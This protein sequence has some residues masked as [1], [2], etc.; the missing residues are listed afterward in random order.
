MIAIL[1]VAV[2]V[3]AACGLVRL[4]CW[5]L[6]PATAIYWG[7]SVIEGIVTGVGVRTITLMLFAGATFLQLFYFIG[8]L[9]FDEQK[10]AAPAP[11]PLRP[12]LARAMQSAIG[13]E[14]RMRYRLPQDLPQELGACL[15]ELKARYG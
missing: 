5:A 8:W 10:G 14:L 2:A 7:I 9:V 1:L 11:R 13:Q 3:G 12:E 6:I 4:K 15:G